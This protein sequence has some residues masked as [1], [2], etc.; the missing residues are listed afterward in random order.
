MAR[1][2][3]LDGRAS[4]GAATY[5]WTQVVDPGDPT[6]TLT[7]ANTA[8]PTFTFPFYKAPAPNNSLTFN[9]KVTSPD[10]SPRATTR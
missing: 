4:T 9:L 3:T 10:G 1:R 6:V 7:G 2:S 5:A 8:Q